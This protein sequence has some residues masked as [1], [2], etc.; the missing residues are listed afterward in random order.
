MTRGAPHWKVAFDL[1]ANLGDWA[2]TV[3]S[4]APEC[5]V[6]C[7]EPSPRTVRTLRTNLAGRENLTVHHLGVGDREGMLAFHDYGD[8]SVMSS[9]LSREGSTGERAE[10]VIDVPIGTLDAFLEAHSIASVDYAKIDTEGYEMPILRGAQEIPIHTADSRA[11]VRVRRH[12]AR[13]GRVPAQ[14]LAALRRPA[15]DALPPAPRRPQSAALRPPPRRD[16]QVLQLRGRG[17]PDGA[18]RVGAEGLRVASFELPLP[19]L[20]P[21]RR[22]GTR[23]RRRTRRPRE[24]ARGT[25]PRAPRAAP[26]GPAR[27]RRPRPRG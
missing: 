19:S 11:S 26:R 4:L 21:T 9:F 3:N 14:R 1:G 18:R 6:H 5:R 25:P 15:L 27:S 13:R 22:R 8:G 7:F 23:R 10:R 20:S 12:L 2:L 16:V 17:R 24:T